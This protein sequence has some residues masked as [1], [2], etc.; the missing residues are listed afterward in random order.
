MAWFEEKGTSNFVVYKSVFFL[1]GMKIFRPSLPSD[2]PLDSF[3]FR[4][5]SVFT[6]F[7]SMVTVVFLF[8]F[9]YI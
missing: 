9:A 2:S 4:Q 7:L 5:D 8:P 6:L 1:L 3:A